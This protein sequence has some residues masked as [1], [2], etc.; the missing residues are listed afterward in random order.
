MDRIEPRIHDEIKDYITDVLKFD[1]SNIETY[2]EP[3][4][5]YNDIQSCPGLG[6][7]IVRSYSGM[8]INLHKNIYEVEDYTPSQTVLENEERTYNKYG[9]FTKG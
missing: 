6:G 4:G 7:Y 1:L 9:K 5:E 3:S 8:V 2:K